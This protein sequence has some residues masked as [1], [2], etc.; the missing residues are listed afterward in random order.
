MDEKCRVSRKNPAETL[1]RYL[2]GGGWTNAVVVV[3]MVMV[4]MVVIVLV[5]REA[6]Q[7]TMHR[8]PRCGGWGRGAARSQ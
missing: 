5:V 7:T 8:N 1:G 2:Q 6:L 4:V 3:V